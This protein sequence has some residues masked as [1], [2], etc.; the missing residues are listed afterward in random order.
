MTD[1]LV[2]VNP[3]ARSANYVI[4]QMTEGDAGEYFC[5][6]FNT[7]GNTSTRTATVGYIADTEPPKVVRATAGPTFNTLVVEF[8]EVV[9]TNTA[10]ETFGYTI[11]PTLGI[12]AVS[13]IPGGTA[14]LL[15]TEMQAADSAY[16]V[17]VTDV[18]DLAL[19]AV[20]APQMCS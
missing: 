16:N 12:S 5:E 6:V 13:L 2:V 18:Y 1:A 19:N 4:S 3:T 15:T 7:V 17:T 11:T 20:A 9:D 14:V 10:L 8:D